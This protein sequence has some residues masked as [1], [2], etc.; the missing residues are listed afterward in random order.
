MSLLLLF[1]QPA[2]AGIIGDVRVTGKVV[3]YDRKTVSLKTLKS[4]KPVVVPKSSIVLPEGVKLKTGKV[5]TAVFSAEEIM[6]KIKKS[7]TISTASLF[8]PKEISFTYN[9]SNIISA[10]FF[11]FSVFAWHLNHFAPV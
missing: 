8:H 11:W 7:K 10:F 3:K 5:A 6:G 2:L 9:Q 1:G 4:S